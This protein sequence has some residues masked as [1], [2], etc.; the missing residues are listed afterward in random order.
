MAQ[1]NYPIRFYF[2][3]VAIAGHEPAVCLPLSVV[4]P[5]CLIRGLS[6]RLIE[7]EKVEYAPAPSLKPNSSCLARGF[8]PSVLLPS[9]LGLP[10]TEC[11]AIDPY[12]FFCYHDDQV[13]SMWCLGVHSL[14][15]R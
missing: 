2:L 14:P 1:T 13:F 5:L 3:W 10:P 11:N 9:L 6:V 8:N 15:H 7:V 4:V 12:H